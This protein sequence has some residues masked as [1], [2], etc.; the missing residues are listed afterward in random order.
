[1]SAPYAPCSPTPRSSSIRIRKAWKP[2]S[3]RWWRDMPLKILTGAEAIANLRSNPFAEWPSRQTE[4]MNRIE[5]LCRPACAQSFRFAPRGK[6]FTMGS[7][8]AR[9][10]ERELAA[11]GF[12]VATSQLA[13]PEKNVETAGN[14]V[15]NNYGVVSIENE[16]R[17]ALD[18]DCPFDPHK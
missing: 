8:F 13:W 4:D 15:L 18:P 2:R 11:R 16:L 14:E 10:V 17:W 7:C 9:N 6:V 5:P 1:S 3:P 12:D